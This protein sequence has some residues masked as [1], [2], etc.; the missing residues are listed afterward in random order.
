LNRYVCVHGHFYQPPREDPWTGYVPLESAAFPFHDWNERITVECYRPNA[1]A[2]ILAHDALPERIVN[3]YAQMSFNFGATLLDWLAKEAPDVY[4]AVLQADRDSTLRFGGHGCALAQ[5]YA[6]AILPLANERDRRTQV[7][8]GV[9]DFEL[10]FGR[11]PAGFWLPETAVDTPTLE[12]LADAGIS[13][14][15]LAPRQALRTRRPGEAWRDVHESSLD[16]TRPYRVDLASGRSIA[17]FFYDGRLSRAVAFENVLRS[18]EELALRLV[19]SCGDGEGARLG[20]I[21]TDGETYGHHHRFGEMALAYAL[22]YIESRGLAMLANYGQFLELAPPEWEAQIVEGSSWSCEHG[23]ERWRSNCGCHAGEHPHYTQEWRAPLREALDWL[24]AHLSQ[25]FETTASG[26]MKDPWAARDGYIDV[27]HD[28][29][30]GPKWLELLAQRSLSQ[31]EVSRLLD[32]FE[33]QRQAIL[34]FASCAWFFEDVAGIETVQA[35]RH[36]ARAIELS[37]QAS[38]PDDTEQR[39]LRLLSLAQSNEAS[40]GNG[41]EVYQRHAKRAH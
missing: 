9:R 13:Y 8:W 14:T 31:A 19:D 20:H 15:V 25:R 18:G 3:N 41:A 12:A 17:V 33:S 16:T 39:F 30:L 37:Q 35:L 7:A 27:V 2:R 21:A 10:R 38:R 28:A 6:H 26:Y 4:E 34:M 24:A 5:G 36:A 29:T 22:Q 40:E 1:V 32:L 23:V 11:A